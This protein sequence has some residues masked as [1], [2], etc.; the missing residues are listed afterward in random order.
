MPEDADMFSDLNQHRQHHTDGNQQIID[1]I[2]NNLK[3]PNSNDSVEN[4]KSIIYLSQINQA[5]SLKT[6]TEFFR[7]N[8]NRIDPKTGNGMCMGTMYWQFND[9]WQ[10]PTWS[11]IEFSCKWKLKS[12]IQNG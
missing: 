6:G 2:Q 3:L 4:F 10:A 12:E 9:V 11:T 5:M 8:K 1:E 7:R